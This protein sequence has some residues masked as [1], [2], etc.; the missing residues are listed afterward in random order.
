MCILV[1]DKKQTQG[2]M[3]MHAKAGGRQ[4]IQT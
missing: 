2:K 1:N 4:A 3:R